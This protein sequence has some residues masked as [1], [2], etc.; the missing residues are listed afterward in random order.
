MQS[1]NT[2]PSSGCISN[3]R[4]IYMIIAR[5]LSHNASHFIG[6]YHN[7]QKALR[8]LP[9]IPASGQRQQSQRK[10]TGIVCVFPWWHIA[11][12]SH[13]CLDGVGVA[14]RVPLVVRQSSITR[15][16][17]PAHPINAVV[18]IVNQI[19]VMI[20]WKTH[21]DRN[22]KNPWYL[23]VVHNGDELNVKYDTINQANSQIICLLDTTLRWYRGGGTEA[24][25]WT[26]RSWTTYSTRNRDWVDYL[27]MG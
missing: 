14:S 13:D 19:L 17:N 2:S 25:F 16:L 5:L 9:S 4:H 6:I 26:Q 1:G 15:R 8:Q 23:T 12:G 24:H 20:V 22:A 21:V 27:D 10:L 7:S 18:I 11:S 3:H